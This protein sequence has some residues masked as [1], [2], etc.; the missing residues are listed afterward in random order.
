MGCE[1]G[2]SDRIV[3]EKIEVR[4]EKGR[5]GVGEE[6]FYLTTATLQS[7]VQQ[8]VLVQETAALTIAAASFVILS[9]SVLLF[10]I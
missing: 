4:E 6:D 3:E 8:D 9:L 2:L 10:F 1:G 7:K 5:G